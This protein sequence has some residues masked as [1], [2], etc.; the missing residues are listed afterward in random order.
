[1][2]GNLQPRDLEKPKRTIGPAAAV[3]KCAYTLLAIFKSISS[4]SL[5]GSG[6]S[7]PCHLSVYAKVNKLNTAAPRNLAARLKFR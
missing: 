5:A 1:M 4:L 2:M 3:R 7:A 6:I